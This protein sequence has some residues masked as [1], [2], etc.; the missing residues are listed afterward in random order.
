[1]PSRRVLWMLLLGGL[2]LLLI[3]LGFALRGPLTFADMAVNYAAKQTCSC[4]MVTGRSM[5]SCLLDYPAD[6][7]GQLTVTEDGN[8]FRA[9]ALFGA[10][11]AEAV[12]EDG[13]G[14]RLV[15]D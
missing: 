4:R 9:S 8:T 11:K 5:D 14:C 12:Y 15:T 1:M 6:A 7:R 3:G 13:F 2:A 10:F